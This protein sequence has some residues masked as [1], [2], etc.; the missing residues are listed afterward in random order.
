MKLFI[1]WSGE[2]SGKV[3][4][5]LNEWIPSVI[6]SIKP[7]LSNKDLEKG[8]RW[9]EE[10]TKQLASMDKGI[11]CAT[12]ESLRSPWVNFEAG[13]L[14]KTSQANVYPFLF[15]LSREDLNGSP[16]RQFQS[17]KYEK[18]DVEKLIRA[19]NKGTEN[20]IKEELL[21]KEFNKTKWSELD[22]ALKEVY[23]L[24][25]KKIL[26]VHESRNPSS[27]AEIAKIEVEGVEFQRKWY[28]DESQEPNEKECD[29]LVYVFR[30]SPESLAK[31]R[32]AIDFLLALD[33]KIPMI[34]YAPG[35]FLS[36]DELQVV[37][38]HSKLASTPPT[39]ADRLREAI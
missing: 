3:A 19:L 20:P 4:Q 25:Q 12:K 16:L 7:F 5:I 33:K 36:E 14:S 17:T 29:V 34:V 32:Q 6:Q 1:S 35:V 24:T 21:I 22:E 37:K 31:L 11:V 10:L 26:W 15:G 28:L 39:L 30:K 13:A 2:T 27:E 18:A 23:P 8:E 9:A 38:E